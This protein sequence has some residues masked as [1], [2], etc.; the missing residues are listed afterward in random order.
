MSGQVHKQTCRQIDRDKHRYEDKQR[1]RHT[2]THRHT[3]MQTDR[4]RHG[5]EDSYSVSIM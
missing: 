5:Y 1:Q 4:P 2:D 3:N